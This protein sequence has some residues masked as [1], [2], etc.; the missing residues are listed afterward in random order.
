M[1]GLLA[2]KK[3]VVIRPADIDVGWSVF[4]WWGLLATTVLDILDD[5]L[6]AH[7]APRELRPAPLS[8]KL[9][10]AE[11]VAI[12]ALLPPSVLFGIGLGCAWVLCGL[13]GGA[14]A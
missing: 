10:R 14:R 7:L 9:K 8:V 12:I 5:A 13:R 11:R 3:N 1:V 2:D 4:Q 6:V